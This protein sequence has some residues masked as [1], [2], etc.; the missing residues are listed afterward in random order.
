MEKKHIN[1]KA[2]YY[3]MNSFQLEY[4]SQKR[5]NFNA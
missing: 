4:F 3:N 1:E 2:I 5:K